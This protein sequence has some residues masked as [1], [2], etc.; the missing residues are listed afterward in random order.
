MSNPLRTDADYEFF[1]YTLTTQFPSIQQSKLC[2]R[3]TM[4]NQ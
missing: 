2:F 3:L 1:L 4:I